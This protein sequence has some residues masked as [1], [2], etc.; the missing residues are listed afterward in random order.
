MTSPLPRLLIATANRH[1]KEE[2]R[3]ML[4][5]IA[6]VA[7]LTDHPHLPR[8]EE[9]GTTFE[10]NSAIKAIAA[11]QATGLPALADD[12]GLEV[13]TLG[14]EPGVR[15]ARYSGTGAT[16]ASNRQ[17]LLDEL[18]RV[19]DSSPRTARFRCVLSL[20]SPDGEILG[21]W[22]GAVEGR[23]IEEER[24]EGGFGYDALF[25]P[26]GHEQTFAELPASTK[27]RLSHRARATAAFL[28]DH[29]RWR[30]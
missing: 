13:D 20:A 2:F 5:G 6:E 29:E 12:S 3:A 23:I 17:K 16:D 19:P 22:S 4:A 9:T 11:A 21:S 14:G 24:G 1:K 7:D 28:E 30:L 25:V 18:A 10:E 26:D 27:N 8:V 15:S